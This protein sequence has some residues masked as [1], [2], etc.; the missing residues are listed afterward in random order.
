VYEEEVAYAAHYMG[1][2]IK[3]IG[4]E[5]LLD[6]STVVCFSDHGEDL[7]GIYEN[8]KGGYELGH[9]EEF[10]HGCLLYEQTQKTVL[11]IKD[12]ELP[13][14]LNIHKQAR[15]VDITPTILDLMNIDYDTTKFDGTSLLK[16]T[17]NE[18]LELLGYSETFY[19]EEQNQTLEKEFSFAKNKKAFTI[20]NRKKIIVH[21]DSDTIEYYDLQKDPKELNNLIQNRPT[22]EH[23]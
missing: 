5:R 15:L 21:L 16:L 4:D 9:P 3:K 1:E 19:P 6:N 12:P 17:K 13:K 20:D 22:L 7:G 2:F 18:N 10:G 11:I 14:G 8:D 23:S